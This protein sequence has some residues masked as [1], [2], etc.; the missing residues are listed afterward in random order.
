MGWGACFLDKRDSHHRDQNVRCFANAIFLVLTGF[1]RL[2]ACAD[3]HPEESSDHRAAQP[4]LGM[5]GASARSFVPGEEIRTP[6]ERKVCFIQ[7]QGLHW[8]PLVQSG[9]T[10]DSPAQG[11]GVQ[12][13]EL[14]AMGLGMEES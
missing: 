10:V 2:F 8:G 14:A 4:H 9:G 1:S 5:K 12:G 3:R 13:D 6:V 11:P 7:Q